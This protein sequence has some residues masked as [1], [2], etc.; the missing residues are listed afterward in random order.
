MQLDSYVLPTQT[1]VSSI[2]IKANYEDN[3]SITGKLH[4][5][6]SYISGGFDKNKPTEIELT[7]FDITSTQYNNLKAFDG[8][9]D[10]VFSSNSSYSYICSCSIIFFYF[11]NLLSADACKIKLYTYQTL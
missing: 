2:Q 1:S 3:E 8:L 6:Y 4:R 10:V 5:D 7:I 11:N 9:N